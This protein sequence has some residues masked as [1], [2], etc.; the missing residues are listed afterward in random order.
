MTR[1]FVSALGRQDTKY[2]LLSFGE[3]IWHLVADDTTYGHW[4]FFVKMKQKE[5]EIW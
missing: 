2:I 3:D 5:R 4:F 1:W